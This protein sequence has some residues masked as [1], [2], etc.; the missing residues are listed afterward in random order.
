M[1]VN[2]PSS[3]RTST[4]TSASATVTAIKGETEAADVT[5]VSSVAE[6]SVQFSETSGKD[7]EDVAEPASVIDWIITVGDK[8][9]VNP[10]V[11]SFFHRRLIGS[12]GSRGRP[13]THHHDRN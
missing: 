6:E 2:R 9:T 4:G 12:R 7:V 13:Q 8:N 3:R 5:E 10:H 1:D 11:A